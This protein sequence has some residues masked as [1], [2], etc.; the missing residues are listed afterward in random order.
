MYNVIHKAMS[1]TIDTDAF[2]LKL[3]NKAIDLDKKAILMTNFNGSEQSEDLST[4]PNCNGF[5]RIR[6]FIL[7]SS[8]NWPI[9]PLPIIPA[10]Q[11]LGKFHTDRVEAQVFQNAVCNWRCWY[12]YVDFKLLSANPKYSAFLT[13]ETLIDY[14]LSESN[15]PSI[16]DL[17]G[18]QPDL[19]PEWVLWTMDVLKAKELHED[20]F[21]WSDDNLSNDFFWKY[22]SDSDIAKI[23]EYKL[24]SRV[25]CFK[26]IDSHSFSINTK[27]SPDLFERQFDLF[28]RL[29]GTG[30]DLYAYV[31]LTS[32][33]QSNYINTVPKFLDKLQSIHINLPLRTVPLEVKNFTPVN[34]REIS[35]KN[36]YLNS[37]YQ[38][39]DVWIKEMESRYSSL[40]RGKLITNVN[41]R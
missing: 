18:G 35:L 12:C 19:V 36:I 24:Y 7:Q 16:I 30:I 33:N 39:I 25:C 40:D 26:G 11:S 4:P 21:L 29:L 34:N 31:T 17:S 41:L 1:A 8:S 13:A 5:G 23:A 15:R 27:A 6:H 37:Q 9:N 20:V 2:S 28:R 38:G 3:R 32:D 22:L 14:Y 10:M